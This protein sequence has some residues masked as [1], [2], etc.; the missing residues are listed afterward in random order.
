M[1]DL[2]L[3][4][5]ITTYF[6]NSALKPA[7]TAFFIFQKRGAFVGFLVLSKAWGKHR[8]QTLAFLANHFF[9][10]VDISRH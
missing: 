6:S 1:A 8:V 2:V 4:V 5:A 3:M 9:L 10:T 7:K